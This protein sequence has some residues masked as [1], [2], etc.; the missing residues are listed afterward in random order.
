MDEGACSYSLAKPKLIDRYDPIPKCVCISC[1]HLHCNFAWM[2]ISMSY[3]LYDRSR[4]ISIYLSYPRIISCRAL[5]LLLAYPVC[6]RE[7]TSYV[8]RYMCV[9][10]PIYQL[11]PLYLHAVVVDNDWHISCAQSLGLREIYM[12]YFYRPSLFSLDVWIEL[13]YDSITYSTSSDHK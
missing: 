1:L 8:D 10:V 12:H 11:Y 2:D 3:I 6:A 9:Y 5:H 13:I 7:G 4:A